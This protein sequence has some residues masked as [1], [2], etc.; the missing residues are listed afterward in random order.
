MIIHDFDLNRNGRFEPAEIEELNKGAFSNLKNFHYFTHVKINGN[1]FEV[2][3]VKD[4]N[5]KIVRDRVVYHFFVPCHVKAAPSYKEIRI[6]VYDESFY[7]SIILLKDQIF[8]ENDA[9]YELDHTVELN[10]EEPYY[11]G[12]VYPEEIVLRFKKRNE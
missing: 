9:A 3:F 4:F 5:A 12:Q 11:F 6:G 7:T 8:F 10:Q 1:P 2:K